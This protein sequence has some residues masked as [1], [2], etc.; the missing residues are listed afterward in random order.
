MPYAPAVER[1]E[2]FAAAL[3]EVEAAL[4]WEELGRAYCH[5]D[6]EGF[7]SEEQREAQRDAGLLVAADLAEALAALPDRGPRRSLYVGAAVAELAPLLCERVV[8]GREVLAFSLD[9]A[10]ARMLDGAL[11]RVGERL[12]LALPRIDV[13]PVGAADLPPC[14]HLWLVS[15]LSDPEAFPALHDRL[16]GRR[17]TELATGRG[18]LPRERA[19]AA[20]LLDAALRPL[21]VPALVTTTSEELELVR[22]ACAARGLAL[23]APRAGRLSPIVGDPILVCRAR[24]L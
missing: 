2:L 20:E 11:A 12:R 5:G 6:G 10:E 13:R 22:A 4:D 24:A 21:A 23:D 7:F 3:C 14:D 19:R 8:L 17:G 16:Y 18:D 9:G 15:V 1:H